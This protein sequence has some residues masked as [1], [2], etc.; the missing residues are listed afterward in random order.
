MTKIATHTWNPGEYDRFKVERSQPFFD[1]VARIPERPIEHIV[2]MGCGTGTLTATLLNRW[3]TAHISGVDQSQSMLAEARAGISNSQI[4]FVDGDME[5]WQPNHPVD[6]LISNAALQW[7]TDDVK[8]LGGW[9]SLLS[10]HAILA[11]QMPNN[12]SSEAYRVHSRMVREPEWQSKL[13][14]LRPNSEDRKPV[15]TY[16]EL[17]LDHGLQVSAWETYY[18]I[19]L[20]DVADIVTWMR[21]TVMG[22]TLAALA[23][24]DQARFLDEFTLQVERVTEPGRHGVWFPFRRMFLVAWR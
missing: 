10:A 19:R 1:L 15:A 2:D 22:P 8:T 23:P 7:A 21:S 9:V 20:A 16:A 11:V 24:E 5:S 6:L 13:N 4:T 3:P 18:Q 17:L 14:G 12:G